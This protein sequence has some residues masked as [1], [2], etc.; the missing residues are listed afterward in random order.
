MGWTF[1]L[2]LSSICCFDMW[3]QMAWLQVPIPTVLL[4]I[5]WPS[6]TMVL[7]VPGTVPAYLSRGFQFPAS[8]QNYSNKAITS[9]HWHRETPYPLDPTKP[10]SHS[11]CLFTVLQYNPHA[12]PHALGCSS[13]PGYEHMW[14]INHCQSHLS[15]V[16]GMGLASSV[17]LEQESLLP[18]WWGD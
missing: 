14:L 18:R 1:K 4:W 15:R 12:A 5:R 17:T 11:P 3:P 16:R 7:E 13:L 2:R 6:P 8:L 9:S 10:A